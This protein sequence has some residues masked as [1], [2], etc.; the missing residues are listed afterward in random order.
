MPL[1]VDEDDAK[2]MMQTDIHEVLT[3][4]EKKAMQRERMRK[5]K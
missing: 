4:R 1:P 2:R 5:G 3:A